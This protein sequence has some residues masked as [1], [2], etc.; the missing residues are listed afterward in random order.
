MERV[1]KHWIKSR[2]V[3]LILLAAPVLA[4]DVAPLPE[5]SLDGAEAGFRARILEARAALD[6]LP[7]A[8]PD[9]ERAAAYGELGSLYLVSELRAA[10]EVALANAR[11][12]DPDEPRWPYFLGI[13]RA[14][15]GNLNGAVEALRAARDLRLDSVAV[16][17][18]LAETLR[19]GG[20][21]EAARELFDEVLSSQG[22]ESGGVLGDREVAFARFGLGRI[23]FD[24]GRWHDAVELLEAVREAVPEATAVG[25]VLG[26]AYRELGRMDEARAAMSAA[27]GVS[28]ALPDPWFEELRQI[29][30][31]AYLAN[32]VQARL[33]EDYE[34]AARLYR[35]AADADPDRSDPAT[36]DALRGLAEVL[37]VLGDG[38]GAVAVLEDA[39]QKYPDHAVLHAKLGE[40]LALSR[41][42]ADA[43]APYRRALELS[44]HAPESHLGLG[45]A[46][47]MTG[48]HE[49]ALQHYGRC[50]ELAP[51]HVEARAL[52]ARALSRLGRHAEA[53]EDL[54]VALAVQPGNVRVRLAHVDALA[55]AGDTVAV[56]DTLEA[57]VAAHRDPRLVAALVQVLIGDPDLSRRDPERAVRLGTELLQRDPSVSHA[58]VLARA[59]FAAGRVAEAAGLQERALQEARSAG[60]P[61]EQLAALEQVLGIYR[62]RL[63]G[64]GP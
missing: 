17:L 5:P 2:A 39:V 7:D 64:N 14:D 40:V 56:R 38:S 33:N 12:L 54:A 63:D 45:R 62:S 16:R 1:T 51:D 50:L 43:V 32:A 41:R 18:R 46:L 30:I 36:A 53:A 23:A 6:R 8:A 27:G 58:I 25:R 13:L 19:V 10:A 28:V 59:L 26:L 44:D 20:D 29:D 9:L 55:Q 48:H 47:A 31:G 3:L 24:E 15:L 11:S 21:L 37:F 34:E 42:P 57:G 22:P 35:L 61:D 49:E 60:A 52:K 4:Q